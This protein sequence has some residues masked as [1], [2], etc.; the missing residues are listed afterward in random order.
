[1]RSTVGLF[2]ALALTVGCGGISENEFIVSYED[3]YCAAYPQC[4]SDEMNQSIGERE[5]HQWYLGAEYP[6]RQDGCIFDGELAEA[7]VVAL[8][9]PVELCEGFDPKLPL[10]CEDVY[11]GCPVPRLPTFE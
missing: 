3:A 7:C 2:A 10:V 8:Q 9:T 1:M 5:C 6:E 11:S 4:A